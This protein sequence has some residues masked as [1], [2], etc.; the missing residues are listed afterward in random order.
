MTT[1]GPCWRVQ[2]AAPT[3]KAEA[4]AKRKAAESLLLVPMVIDTESKLHK[5]RT[6]DCY[7]RDAADRLRERAVSS[8]FDGA[9]PLGI[10]K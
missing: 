8:G 10:P 4:E 5:V 7:A 6:R 2:V 3:D 1:S 9:F